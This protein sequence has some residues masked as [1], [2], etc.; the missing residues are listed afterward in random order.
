MASD[1][2]ALKVVTEREQKKV[3]YQTSGN[4]VQTIVI[5]CVNASGQ[6]IPLFVIFD[7]QRLNMK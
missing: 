5:A 6:C 1:G 2:L 4:K 7:A 3:R